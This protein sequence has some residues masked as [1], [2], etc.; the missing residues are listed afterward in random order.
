[1]ENIRKLGDH[2]LLGHRL[3]GVD[4]PPPGDE[5]HYTSTTQKLYTSDFTVACP[6]LWYSSAQQPKEPIM[7][8]ATSMLPPA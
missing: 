1:L 7:G 4:G 3:A 2:V 6:L 8:E 5:L